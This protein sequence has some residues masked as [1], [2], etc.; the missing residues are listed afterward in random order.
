VG[1]G[2]RGP[3]RGRGGGGGLDEER[4]LTK[5]QWRERRSRSFSMVWQQLMEEM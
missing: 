4:I 1:D 2:E 3:R 5:E